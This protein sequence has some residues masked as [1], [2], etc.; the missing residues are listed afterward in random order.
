MR[1]RISAIINKLNIS[2]MMMIVVLMIGCGQQPEAGKTGAAGGEKQGAGSLSE[3]LMEVGKSAENAFYSFLELVSDTLG[4]T[5]KSTTKKE[6][7]GGYFNSLG[8]K[9]GEASNELE[10]VAKN[11]E[12]GIE[13]NDASKNPIRSA[14]NAAK[15]TLEALKGYLDS[16]GTVGD[17]NPVG[18]A[19][20]NAQGAAVDEAELKKAYKALKGIMDTAEGA[21]V[22]R[23]EV[24]N[25]AVKVG[26]GTDNKDGA[27][28]L[29]TDGAAAV[30]DAGKAAAILTTVSGKEM[31]ASI[32]N[33]T[34]D[35]AV[36]ITGN[37]T[38]ETTPLEFAVGGNGAHLSQNANSKAAA[39]AGGIALRSLVKGG[40]LAANNNDDDKAS[41]GVGIT[42][43]NKLLV[44]VEDI[45][46]KTVKNVLEKAKGEIDKARDPK[47]AGQQ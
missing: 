24:G 28:I 36:K 23:P 39:V 3:V 45:I 8:G 46:K 32:V 37:V 5:A 10:Q 31:L 20:N 7:V 16:L 21:G 38:V 43:A 1:K 47:P 19:S 29:A 41:Q 13:K 30:G 6:D 33:S 4:F 15:K 26:N 27:K 18:W 40:K 12:A 17:S 25:I 42:A 34:E 35:K 22:A 11:S 2:I 44:A 14:V 9:L